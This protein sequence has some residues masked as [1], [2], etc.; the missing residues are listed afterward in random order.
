[1]DDKLSHMTELQQQI[2]EQFNRT[3]GCEIKSFDE[4]ETLK[5]LLPADLLK[6][7]ALCLF[8][9][10]EF[11]AC[12][13]AGAYFSA[14]ISGAAMIEGFLL[15]LCWLNK[16]M[17]SA[18]AAYKKHAKNKDFDTTWGSLSL[19]TLI[20]IAEVLQWIPADLVKMDLRTA[21]AASYEEIAV[22][23][24]LDL[25]TIANG[26]AAL[27]AHPAIALFDLNERNKESFARRAL[28]SG[29]AA[30]QSRTF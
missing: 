7:E 20:E 12:E 18:T 25:K 10:K 3:L 1:M 5:N 9:E 4:L 6:L 16:D 22:S 8:L 13:K 14:C 11:L 15:I 26:K 30:I 27:I 29:K 19:E 21:I 24:G 17:V 2:L 23:K 28:D